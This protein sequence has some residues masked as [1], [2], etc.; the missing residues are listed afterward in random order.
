MQIKI[1][2]M[3]S[4]HTLLTVILTTTSIEATIVAGCTSDSDCGNVANSCTITI[5]E[6]KYCS[7]CAAG[8]VP[9]NGVCVSH[10]ASKGN[11]CS[12]DGCT[13]CAKGYFLHYGSCFNIDEDSA[14]SLVCNYVDESDILVDGYCTMC[15]EYGYTDNPRKSSTTQSCIECSGND[16]VP[17]CNSCIAVPDN[18]NTNGYL[19]ICQD[20]IDNT[21]VAID[22]KCVSIGSQEDALSGCVHRPSSG[23]M[24]CIRCGAGF[25]QFTT[26][27]LLANGKYAPKICALQNQI[28]V[29]DTIC[30]KQCVDTESTIIDGDCSNFN[31]NCICSGGSCTSCDGE[32]YIYHYGGCYQKYSTL[33][34]SICSGDVDVNGRC[35]QCNTSRTS[36]LFNN[37]NTNDMQACVS[38]SDVTNGGIKNCVECSY[39][40]SMLACTKCSDG[41]VP[42]NNQCGDVTPPGPPV[43]DCKILACNICNTTDITRCAKCHMRTYLSVDNKTC[44]SDCRTQNSDLYSYYG[45]SATGSCKTCHS[46]CRNCTGPGVDQ[47]TGCHPGKYVPEEV[48]SCIPCSSSKDGSGFTGIQNCVR[49]HKGGY[50]MT[51][52]KCDACSNNMIPNFNHEHCIS[53]TVCS[54]EN[55]ELCQT[56]LS[57]CDRCK[58]GF[59]LTSNNTCIS[60]CKTLGMCTGNNEMRKCICCSEGCISCNTATHCFTCQSDY[61]LVNNEYCFKCDSTEGA[62]SL[63][64]VPNCIKCKAPSTGEGFVRCLEYSKEPPDEP[65]PRSSVGFAV[66]VTVTI[67]IIAGLVG[68]LVWWFVCKK[69]PT[70]AKEPRLIQSNT[71]MMSSHVS[72]I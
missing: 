29:A 20:C 62:H 70:R 59:F 32:T 16:G 41:T 54:T 9:I 39:E 27:C 65:D 17:G 47:C 56:N 51:I 44:V 45:D 11:T 5:D 26:T 42:T 2:M 15:S 66:G 53:P 60:D 67:L 22:N 40:S 33:G 68:F 55:C 37:P 50:T 58:E 19:V 46:D 28:H 69:R 4:L 10:S 6:L 57:T 61:A 24:H 43:G 30:C 49:C 8:N 35:L 48:G 21:K 71:S 25:L 1:K 12:A 72:I 14:G 31:P 64:G 38:C 63:V 18:S 23:Y 52:L 34:R 3:V 13:Q 7:K 36:G